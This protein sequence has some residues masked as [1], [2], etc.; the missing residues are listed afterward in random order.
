MRKTFLLLTLKVTSHNPGSK[1]SL[2]LAGVVFPNH[3]PGKFQPHCSR[4]FR[5]SGDKRSQKRVVA[6]PLHDIII[7]L[8]FETA[9]SHATEFILL[10]RLFD[11]RHN[12]VF[13]A[14]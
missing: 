6:R 10:L 9:S 13:P 11:F 12:A 7:S 14:P 5:S 1:E 8:G 4:D 3:S 2:I